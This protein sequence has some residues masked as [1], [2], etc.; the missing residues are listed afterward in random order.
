MTTSVLLGGHL[1][2][3]P[4]LWYIAIG[5]LIVLAVVAY[6][7]LIRIYIAYRM[8]KNRHRPPLG[9]SLLSFFTSPLGIW[10]LLLILGDNKDPK[11][12]DIL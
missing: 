6:I 12:G 4:S 9:W 7:A 10:I 2:V 5:I 1:V 3:D 8:A 11:D